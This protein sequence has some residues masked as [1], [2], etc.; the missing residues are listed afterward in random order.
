MP[1]VDNKHVHHVRLSTKPD[2]EQKEIYDRLG[3]KK[4]TIKRKRITIK[5][6]DL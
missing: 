1:D 2:A 6:A 3:I 4:T 5:K